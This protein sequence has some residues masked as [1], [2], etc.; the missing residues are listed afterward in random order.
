MRLPLRAA[1]CSLQQ[2][3]DVASF[4]EPAT[5]AHGTERVLT[6]VN[7]ILLPPDRYQRGIPGELVISG[8]DLAKVFPSAEHSLDHGA[9]E[10]AVAVKRDPLLPSGRARDRRHIRRGLREMPDRRGA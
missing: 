6:S 7:R 2:E 1:R 3:W 4:D 8:R 9:L 5:L 10:I